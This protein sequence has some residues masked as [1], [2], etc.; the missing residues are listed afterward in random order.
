MN[1]CGLVRYNELIDV[2]HEVII[3]IKLIATDLD[4]T[5]LNA[6]RGVSPET[7]RVLN[8]VRSLGI[9]VVLATGRTYA[10]VR[11]IYD[12]LQLDSPVITN[13]GGLIY[14]PVTETVLAGNPLPAHVL[15]NLL[16]WLDERKLYNQFYTRDTIYTRHLGFLSEEWA[17]KN[18]DLPERQ[19]IRIELLGEGPLP[20]ALETEPFYKLLVMD[21]NPEVIAEVRAHIATIPELE[22]TISIENGL[23]ILCAGISKGYGLKRLA[24]VLEILPEEIMAFGDQEN[25]IEM[26]QF[27]G[28]GVAMENAPDHV[29]AYA[30]QIAPLHDDDG[31]ARFIETFFA[32]KRGPFT[33]A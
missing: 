13:N 29:K 5:L 17:K 12:V 24:E 16:D 10:G 32:C 3:L 6:E 27:A 28:I 25:D 23:D 33:P 9:I 11:G 2:G 31:L 26:L 19:R 7:L 8:W 15:R 14:D 1:C 21:R 22:T 20:A 4:G 30:E 18:A